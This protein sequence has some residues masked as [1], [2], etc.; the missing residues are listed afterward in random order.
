MNQDSEGFPEGTLRELIVDL[1]PG[2]VG[3]HISNP[4]TKVQFA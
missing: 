2:M 4:C 3:N 1:P